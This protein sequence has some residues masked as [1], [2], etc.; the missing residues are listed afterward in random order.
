MLQAQ[1]QRTQE[2]LSNDDISNLTIDQIDQLDFP[3]LEKQYQKDREQDP[4]KD[5]ISDLE[6]DDSTQQLENEVQQLEKEKE[7]Y[8]NVNWDAVRVTPDPG[9]SDMPEIR[10]TNRET[11]GRLPI[12]LQREVALYPGTPGHDALRY[13]VEKPNYALDPRNPTHGLLSWTVCAYDECAVH[14]STKRDSGYYPVRRDICNT[15][16]NACMN[17]ACERHLIDKREHRNFPGHTHEWRIELRKALS[18]KDTTN[19]RQIHW[20]I[21]LKTRCERHRTLKEENGFGPHQR[22]HDSNGLRIATMLLSIRKNDMIKIPVTINGWHKTRALI[23]TG[24]QGTFLS[25]TFATRAG[26]PL[27]RKK[28][29]IGLW[30]ANGYEE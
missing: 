26:I 7:R 27:Q 28:N 5:E 13:L 14:H 15:H 29:P 1:Q 20:Q 24:A 17:D 19:C 21:C 25:R 12:A 16:W 8:Q 11:S 18:R 2:W 30:M 4:T 6:L 22:Q 23:D 3:E 10:T 9:T